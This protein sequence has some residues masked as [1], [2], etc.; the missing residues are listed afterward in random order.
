MRGFL[1]GQKIARKYAC[2]KQKFHSVCQNEF[3]TGI[4][5]SWRGLTRPS[6]S[7]ERSECG[8]SVVPARA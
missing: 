1:Y 8:K 7:F 2:G 6:T 5:S 3:G 4:S